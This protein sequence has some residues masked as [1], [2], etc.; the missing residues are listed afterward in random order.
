MQMGKQRTS[1]TFTPPGFQSPFGRFSYDPTAGSFLFSRGEELE[2]SRSD[3]S[4]R[5]AFL[6]QLL[7]QLGTSSAQRE[8]IRSRF[9]QAFYDRLRSRIQENFS[10]AQGEVLEQL[11]ARNLLGSSIESSRLGDLEA[12][13]MQSTIEAAREA[14]LE[15]EELRRQDEELKLALTRALEQ[16][17][18][19]EF[20]RRLQATRLVTGVGLKGAGLHQRAEEFYSQVRRQEQ[21][22]QTKMIVD[23]IGTIGKILTPTPI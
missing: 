1:T 3:E 18:T 11:G 14:I 6:R 23:L 5:R 22:D 17:I 16:G 21:Q 4:M 19:D 12:K 7:P 9:E 2:E 13:R 8:A 10:Q 20:G 15:S